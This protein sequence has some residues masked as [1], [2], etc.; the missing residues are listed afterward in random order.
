MDE[1]ALQHWGLLQHLQGEEATQKLPQG[2][3]QQEQ[4]GQQQLTTPLGG[5]ADGGVGAASHS[6]ATT[7]LPLLQSHGDQVLALPQGGVR[8]AS[9][10]DMGVRGGRREE[11]GAPGLLR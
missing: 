5:E 7:V 3:Q 11:G 10:G 8:L 6:A 9:S 4:Q 2:Q 1:A